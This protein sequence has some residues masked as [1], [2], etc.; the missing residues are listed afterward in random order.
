MP[1]TSAANV[2]DAAA[3]TASSG[4]RSETYD[5]CVVALPHAQFQIT[6]IMLKTG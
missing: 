3:D 1:S 4:S 6:L 5:V 2:A